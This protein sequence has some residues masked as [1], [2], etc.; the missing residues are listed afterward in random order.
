MLQLN[1]RDVVT[2]LEELR[3]AVET[4]MA[5]PVYN[6]YTLK[7]IML[8]KDLTPTERIILQFLSIQEHE[9][10]GSFIMKHLGMK[11]KGFRNNI[12]NLLKR[13]LVKRG[14]GYS[15]WIINNPKKGVL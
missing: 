12:E 4:A 10:K 9:V 15:T 2:S 11:G 14:I 5:E 8:K 13:G 3:K 1:K 7:S 6:E